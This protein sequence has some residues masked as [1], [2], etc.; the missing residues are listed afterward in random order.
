MLRVSA[1]FT[2]TL[3]PGHYDLRGGGK[4]ATEG[5]AG[6]G[7][8]LSREGLQGRALIRPAWLAIFSPRHSLLIRRHLRTGEL[9][10]H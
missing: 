1:S 9:A 7:D 3:A 8:P 6:L 10:F 4:Q 5:L 2:L